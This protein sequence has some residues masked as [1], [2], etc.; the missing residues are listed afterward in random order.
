[1]PRQKDI[2]YEQV[3]RI[4]KA[5]SSPKRLEIINLLSQGGKTVDV[6]AGELGMDIKLT[7]AHLKSLK[8]AS[9]VSAQRDGKFMI[10]QL[11]GQDVARLW[12]NLREVAEAHL[13]ELRHALGE[14]T[15]ESVTLAGMD[16]ADLLERARQG[17]LMVIDLRPQAEYALAHLPFARSVPLAELEARLL[18][19]PQDREIIAYCRGP[20]CLMADQAIAV[21]S[22]RGFRVRKIRDGVNEWLAAGMPL[23]STRT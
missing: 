12:I 11:A 7:S 2:F 1:M 5:I 4:G 18:E 15:A 14:M 23:E 17:E 16:R 9:L 10:Y 3:A 22:S 20:Y 13:L 8:G 6:I 19:L 21:L